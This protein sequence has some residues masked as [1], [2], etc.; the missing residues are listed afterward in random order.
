MENANAQI[1]KVKNAGIVLT[2]PF[3]P[4]FIVLQDIPIEIWKPS[5]SELSKVNIIESEDL[6]SIIISML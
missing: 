2:T 4:E 5:T 1:F 3:L 6:L